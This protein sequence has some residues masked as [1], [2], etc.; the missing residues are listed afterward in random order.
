MIIQALILS[1]VL[2]QVAATIYASKIKNDLGFGIAFSS[3]VWT[4]LFFVLAVVY[5]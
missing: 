5:G 3:S 1:L 4:S 2:V